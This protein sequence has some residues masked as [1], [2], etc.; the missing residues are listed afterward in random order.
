[1]GR[2]IINNELE[3]NIGTL[4]EGQLFY[5]TDTKKI[6]KGTSAGNEDIIPTIPT[7]PKKYIV[8]ITVFHTG[9]ISAGTPITNT[10]GTLTWAQIGD[11]GYGVSSDNLFTVGKTFITG[12]LSYRG[13]TQE[14]TPQLSF[15]LAA[16]AVNSLQFYVTDS[17]GNVATPVDSDFTFIISIEVYA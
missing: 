6:Y 5:A 7:V 10:L 13:G 14:P 3:E 16:F 2:F 1:M 8:P 15:V 12:Q 9:D 11:G 4:S 17:L